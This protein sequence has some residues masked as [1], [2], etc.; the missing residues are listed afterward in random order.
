M[1][2]L[3][4]TVMMNGFFLKTSRADLILTPP[5]GEYGIDSVRVSIL[6][7]ESIDAEIPVVFFMPGFDGNPDWYFSFLGIER[8]IENTPVGRSFISVIIDPSFG[9]NPCVWVN[10]ETAGNW[11]DLICFYLTEEISRWSQENLGAKTRPFCLLGHSLGGFGALRIGSRHPD[12]FPY[13]G[14]VSG[15][16]TADVFDYWT[17]YIEEENVWASPELYGP[18]HFF[19]RLS[20]EMSLNF[21]GRGADELFEY[22]CGK[23]SVEEMLLEKIKSGGFDIL[24][25][26]K[27]GSVAFLNEK[28][29][30][31]SAE[32]DIVCRVGFHA[33]LCLELGKSGNSGN[34]KC[35]VFT[36]DHI[37][38]LG[39]AISECLQFF[40]P[41]SD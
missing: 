17:K 20:D 5:A 16:V 14:S 27:N 40:F 23:L 31:A 22:H 34:S 12:I 18:E 38:V 24:Y 4:M 29:Y 13:I 21:T 3:I 28:I 35:S 37:S 30:I 15:I 36:A 26:L 8:I 2:Y 11:E 7:P 1:I 32:K 39:P 10:S 25:S 41:E 19:T 6:Y 9:E 33:E